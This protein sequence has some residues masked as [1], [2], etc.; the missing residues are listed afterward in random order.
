MASASSSSYGSSIRSRVEAKCFRSRA[1]RSVQ[2]AWVLPVHDQ[3]QS[4]PWVVTASSRYERPTRFRAICCFS[5]STVSAKPLDRTL[6]AWSMPNPD[7]RPAALLPMRPASN[8]RMWASGR[9]SASL[10]AAANP[11]KPAPTTTTSAF[12]GPESG[13]AGGTSV[14][15]SNQPL[16]LSY[17]GRSVTAPIVAS[18]VR[19]AGR[20]QERSIQMVFSSVY[21][22][23]A[24]IDLSRPPKPDCLNPPKGV[25]MSPSP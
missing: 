22:S 20:H 10:R 17:L 24:A 16:F 19:S 5:N 1:P 14:R 12:V 21:C 11:V 13:A 3:S 2:A 6:W 15:V 8:R 18:P 7:D 9:S 4:M 23:W 25:V